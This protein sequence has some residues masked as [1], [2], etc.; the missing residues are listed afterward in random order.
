MNVDRYPTG[1]GGI[2]ATRHMIYGPAFD[3]SEIPSNFWLT[4]RPCPKCGKKMLTDGKDFACNCGHKILK[5]EEVKKME[6]KESVKEEVETKKMLRIGR[7]KNA[8]IEE[9]R[10]EYDTIAGNL[11]PHD[12]AVEEVAKRHNISIGYAQTLVSNR[13]Q[14]AKEAEK[15][16]PTVQID[17]TVTDH[18]REALVRDFLSVKQ[19]SEKARRVG[20]QSHIHGIIHFAEQAGFTILSVSRSGGEITITIE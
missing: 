3:R 8:E 11:M 4:M 9:I 13:E 19:L 16:E 15:T 2:G 18:T 20:K 14:K 6:E 10:K 5:N 17:T 7:L 12:D 1:D